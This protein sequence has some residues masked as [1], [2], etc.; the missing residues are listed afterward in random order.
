MK[1]T[2]FSISY[3][4]LLGINMNAQWPSSVTLINP[5]T[6]DSV[7]TEGDLAKGASMSDL[8]WAWNS[9]N[10]CFPAT[11][12]AKFKGH[13][14]FFA[15]TMPA[16]C[17]MKISVIPTDPK[18]DLSVYAYRIGAS[19]YSLVP[20]LTRCI[21]CEADHKWDRKW[22]GKEQTSERK[23]SFQNPGKEVYN[24]LIGVSGP[25]SATSGTFAVK[26]KFEK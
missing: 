4:L 18:A 10:A 20:E 25:A 19:D 26:V 12:A 7:I 15:I 14:V 16:L 24:I 13:H 3:V 1:K 5:G 2:I 11:Q 17:Q 23:V 9:A 22:K 21:T 6:V 8:S